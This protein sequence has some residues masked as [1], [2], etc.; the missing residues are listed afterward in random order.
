MKRFLLHYLIFL[1]LLAAVSE[2][3]T[4]NLIKKGYDRH[5]SHFFAMG[6]VINGGTVRYN[7]DDFES[8]IGLSGGVGFDIAAGSRM[9]IGIACDLH[10]TQIFEE[11]EAMLNVSLA[12]K[13]V[14]Y[15]HREKVAYKPYFAVGIADLGGFNDIIQLEHTQYLTFKAAFEVV[16]FGR[17]KYVWTMEV[18]VWGSPYCFNHDYDITFGPIVQARVGVMFMN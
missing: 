2:A 10:D 3:A 15:K 4:G 16:F 12:I 14:I 18:G 11:R 5:R 13:P 1:C 6:G 9:Y 7:G 17:Q 8:N